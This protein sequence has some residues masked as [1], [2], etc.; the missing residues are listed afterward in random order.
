MTASPYALS[1]IK[2]AGVCGFR[3]LSVAQMLSC[4][5]NEWFGEMYMEVVVV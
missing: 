1:H 2:Q 4:K 5:M 3:G